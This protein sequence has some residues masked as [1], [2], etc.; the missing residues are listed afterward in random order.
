MRDHIKH[1][2]TAGVKREADSLGAEVEVE[3][4]NDKRLKHWPTHADEVIVLD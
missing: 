1:E 4:L 2:T 3:F